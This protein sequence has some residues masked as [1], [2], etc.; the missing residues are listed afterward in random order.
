VWQK[1]A[2]TSSE[3]GRVGECIYAEK[4]VVVWDAF[5]L[6]AENTFEGII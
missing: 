2:Q 6:D 4:Q 3:G 5:I 1:Q